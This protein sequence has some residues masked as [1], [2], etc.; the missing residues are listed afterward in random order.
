[1]S[2][3]KLYE[4]P[5]ARADAVHLEAHLRLDTG[6]HLGPVRQLAAS[7]DGR[8]LVSAGDTSLRVWDAGQRTLVRRLLGQIG[9]ESDPDLGR[10]RRFALSPDGRWAAVLKQGPALPPGAAGGGHA[11]E[12][13]VF[14]LATGNLQARFEHA[15]SLLDL[16]YSPDGRWLALAGHRIRASV[17]Q[18]VL[19]VHSARAVAR[20]GLQR[21][22]QPL[23]TRSVGQAGP[24]GALPLALRCVPG[25][26]PRGAACTLVLAVGGSGRHGSSLVWVRFAPGQG[27]TVTR[28]APQPVPI[29]PGTLAVSAELAVVASAYVRGHWARSRQGRLFWHAHEGPAAGASVTEALVASTSFAP[30]GRHLLAGLMTD[31]HAFGMP[32]AGAQTVPVHA[33]AA[34]P[35][36][37][38]LQ[39]THYGHDSTVAATA[40]LDATTALSA[41]GDDNAMHAWSFVH[42]VADLRWAIR[43]V[44]R[45]I[46]A[47][48]VTP[49]LQVLFGTVPQ[50]LR[51][52]RHPGRHL[53]FD[54]RQRRLSPL[55]STDPRLREL[56]SRRWEVIEDVSPVIPLR[57]CG[58]E[59]G[60]A[61]EVPELTL[62]VGADHEWVLWSR[63]GYFDASPGGT[64]RVGYHV[65]R[66][67]RREALFVPAD[68]FHAAYRPDLIDAV[69]RYGSEQRARDRGYDIPPLEVAAMLPPILELLPGGVVPGPT[70]VR[71][72]F[73]VENLCPMYPVTRIWILRN[74]RPVWT[75]AQPQRR[76]RARYTVTLQ[77]LPGPNVFSLHAQSGQARAVPVLHRVQGPAAGL[78]NEAASGNLYLLSVGVS[79]FEVAGTPEARGVRRL[80]FAHLDAAAL[81]R[82]LGQRNR[83]FDDVKSRVLVNAKATKA[84]ILDE[85]TAMCDRIHERAA[86]AGAERDV[87]FVFLSGH[88]VRFRGEPDLYFWCHDL[89]LP[90]METS[91]LSM[92][93]LG[94]LITAVPAEVVLVV[95]ACHA[96]MAGGNVVSGLDPEELAR[97]VHA[98]NERGMYVL[99]AARS[100]EDARE[101]RVGRLGVFTGALLATLRSPR[102]LRADP[103]GSRGRSLS[104][105]GLIAG[106]Q[107]LVPE[108]SAR[109]GE[110]AQTPVCRMFGD[111]LPLTIHRT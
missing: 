40:F 53:A 80:R 62:F 17:R 57:P 19:I 47:P 5:L 32:M 105:I 69:V 103:P 14:D 86:Q 39:S 18:A 27:L 106:L 58:Q 12:V 107:E 92:L 85:L 35:Q 55:A 74:E 108:I 2:G 77:L 6:T 26:R 101:D 111:L 15:G 73:R 81:Q 48:S 95:D 84:A 88:G 44:G 3:F 76:A 72:S 9:G 31:A 110:P 11:T 51:P 42:R 29:N 23:A 22:P 7:A 98:V 64:G 8:L 59:P 36:G 104:M 97:R 67:P 43:G 24:D 102:F 21:A 68:R 66:G 82:G 109:S 71:F 70:E 45:T 4:S 56:P 37:L 96:A 1:M 61:A 25:I 20:A 91:G 93:E 34:G 50:R 87:L 90:T 83:A 33:Y 75:L 13:Q 10:I 94:R 100:E 60:D 78:Q 30:G 49:S 41:G 52:P 28:R 54:L 99:S 65:N 46:T 38:M 89:R 16:A 63:S 79:D